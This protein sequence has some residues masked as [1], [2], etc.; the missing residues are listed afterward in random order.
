MTVLYVDEDPEAGKTVCE[1]LAK[2]Y[3]TQRIVHAGSVLDA[4]VKIRKYDPD[5]FILALY[6][7]FIEGLLLAQEILNKGT[8][9]PVI[10]L[11]AGSNKETIRLCST[12]GKVHCVT[13]PV[14]FEALF[15]KLDTLMVEVFLKRFYSAKQCMQH[16]SRGVT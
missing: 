7:P 4:S 3:P 2:N 15:Y 8:E 16:S 13:K 5:M 9:H 1:R 12:I 11:S 6:M 10:F 14:D